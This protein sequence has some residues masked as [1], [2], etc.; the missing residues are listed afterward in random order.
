M[1]YPKKKFMLEW[2]CIVDFRACEM[3]KDTQWKSGAKLS[4]LVEYVW[5]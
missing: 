4:E 2:N 3:S 1:G 5:K